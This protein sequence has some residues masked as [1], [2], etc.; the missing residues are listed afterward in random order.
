[1]NKHKVVEIARQRDD[2]ATVCAVRMDVCGY[3]PTLF[4]SKCDCHSRWHFY[5]KI[6]AKLIA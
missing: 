3:L 5:R 2:E 4:I 1:M 6:D